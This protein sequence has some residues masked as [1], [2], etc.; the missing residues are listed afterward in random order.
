MSQKQ[1]IEPFIVSTTRF[2]NDEYSPL[3][4]IVR[5]EGI[6]ITE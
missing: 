6:E 1:V 3:L 4:E 5:Q 2:L